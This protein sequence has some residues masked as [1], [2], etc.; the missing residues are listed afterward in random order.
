MVAPLVI[1]GVAAASALFGALTTEGVKTSGKAYLYR[2]LHKH[3]PEIERWAMGAVFEKMGLPDLV[4]G[5]ALNQGAFTDAINAKIMGSSEFKFSN[6]FDRDAIRRDAFKFGVQQIGSQAG[7]EVDDVS[8]AGLKDAIKGH[9]MKLVEEEISAD[10]VGELT[11]DAKDVWEIVQLYKAYK[12]AAKD[13]QAAENG[14]RKPL[15]NTPEAAANRARQATYRKAHKKRWV[16][17]DGAGSG[18]GS[19]DDGE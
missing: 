15:I 4:E 12:K 11:Q 10:E 3:R 19:E 16:P 5:G 8:E 14:G 7:F 1:A 17:K 13:G 18:G 2:Q 9:I 6:I